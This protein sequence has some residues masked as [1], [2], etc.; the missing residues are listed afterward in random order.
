MNIKETFKKMF[1]FIT[2]NSNV[3]PMTI[4]DD[5]II[6][7][8]PDESCLVPFTT[9]E[10]P[11]ISK[12]KWDGEPDPLWWAHFK[13]RWYAGDTPIDAYDA[14]KRFHHPKDERIL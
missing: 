14:C 2:D 13:N 3:I 10:K 7:M 6:P 11:K 5:H 12:S 8:M 4:N 9:D 1:P